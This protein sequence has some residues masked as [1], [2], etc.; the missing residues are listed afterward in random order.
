MATLTPDQAERAAH[1][2]I[3]HVTQ[4][5]DTAQA[6][7]IAQKIRPSVILVMADILHIDSEAHGVAWLRRAVVA[8]ARA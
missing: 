1:T 3:T 4:A 6:L 5:R 7:G 2:F 8:E